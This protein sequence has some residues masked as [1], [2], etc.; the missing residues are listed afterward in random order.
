LNLLTANPLGGNVLVI[1]GEA[2]LNPDYQ[3]LHDGYAQK[4]LKLLPAITMTLEQL[5]ASYSLEIRIRPSWV[6]A[7]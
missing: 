1:N 2:R 5:A 3:Q 4:Y 7:I 6:R